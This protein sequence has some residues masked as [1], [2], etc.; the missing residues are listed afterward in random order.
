M[1]NTRAHTPSFCIYYILSLW[2][3]FGASLEGERERGDAM[4]CDEQ[5]WAVASKFPPSIATSTVSRPSSFMVIAAANPCLLYLLLPPAQLTNAR[6]NVRV[7]WRP[8]PSAPFFLGRGRAPLASRLISITR[9]SG[10]HLA[11]CHSQTLMN[12]TNA[13]PIADD[14]PLDF[15]RAHS[16]KSARSANRAFQ[17]SQ[18][19][20]K[21]VMS[22][23]GST[24]RCYP[25]QLQQRLL[26]R[27]RQSSA[28]SHDNR[29]I[30][31]T[32]FPCSG[33]ITTLPTMMT[34]WLPC[35]KYG[36]QRWRRAV[37][38]RASMNGSIK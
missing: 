7:F 17:I 2:N 29:W 35:G 36:R 5:S 1:H 31:P 4:R 26:H 37:D 21:S 6:E 33:T 22:A 14:A 27:L 9:Q 23:V 30:L 19:S 16:E 3:V 11:R 20:L 12:I 24:P 15:A 34:C 13:L 38:G 18:I 32:R 28:P 25:Q 10:L 8:F